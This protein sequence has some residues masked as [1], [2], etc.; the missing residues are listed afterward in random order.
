MRRRAWAKALTW[1]LWGTVVL[2][3]VSL[4]VTGSLP[5]AGAISLA[6]ALIQLPLYVVHEWVWERHGRAAVV[7]PR[8]PD[9]RGAFGNG[10]VEGGSVGKPAERVP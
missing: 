1:R 5:R 7:R 10:R 6:Y 3:G 9:V 4:G 8:A 2:G